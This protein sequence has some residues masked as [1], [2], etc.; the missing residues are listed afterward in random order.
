MFLGRPSKTGLLF[1]TSGIA[2]FG[3]LFSNLTIV[4]EAQVASCRTG[5][6]LD[7]PGVRGRFV[8]VEPVPVGAAVRIPWAEIAAFSP[9][10]FYLVEGGEYALFERGGVPPHVYAHSENPAA[11]AG[12]LEVRRPARPSEM[13]EGASQRFCRF[14][15]DPEAPPLDLVWVERTP[16]ASASR[17]SLQSVRGPGPDPTFGPSI[18]ARDPR[19]AR[20]QAAFYGLEALS[21]AV[22]VAS[23]ARWLDQ[24]RRARPV[25]HDLKGP[26]LLAHLSD[27][28][29]QHLRT[30]NNLMVLGGLLTIGGGFVLVWALWLEVGWVSRAHPVPT[31]WTTYMRIASVL[32]WSAL[33]G[34]CWVRAAVVRREYRAWTKPPAPGPE[35]S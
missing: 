34:A 24:R 13:P 25:R 2:L 6:P 26:P 12:V 19:L 4:G 28:T 16:A 29:A 1:L 33:V 11:E 21:G 27:R 17:M 31:A 20:L 35:D 15:F 9:G 18:E 30:L 14:V 10:A 23:G 8:I 5:G 3:L 22:F 32:L 7:G